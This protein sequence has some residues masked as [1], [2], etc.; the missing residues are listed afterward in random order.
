MWGKW[1]FVEALEDETRRP[2]FVGEQ[3]KD[4]GKGKEAVLAAWKGGEGES[5]KVVLGNVWYNRVDPE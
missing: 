2:F 5:G 1:D 4:K 3:A